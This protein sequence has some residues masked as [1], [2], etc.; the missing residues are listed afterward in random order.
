L[1]SK[2]FGQL[3]VIAFVITSSIA[4]WVTN[5][6]LQGLA[7]RTSIGFGVFLIAT[8]LPFLVAWITMSYHAIKAA[9]DDPVNSIRYE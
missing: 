7:Y 4:W 1:L 6:W 3:L 8:V 9:T 2:N 5:N